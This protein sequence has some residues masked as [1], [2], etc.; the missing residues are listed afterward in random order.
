M[1]FSK[2][3]DKVP[4]KRLNYKLSWYGIRGDTL[5]WIS[6][7]LSARS[8]REVLDGASCDSAP[9]LSGVPQGTVRGP[10]LLL[11]YINDLPD[12]VVNSRPTVRLFADD[13]NFYRLIRNKKDSDLLQSDLDAV[14]SWENTL[15]TQFN[16]D[17]YF[18]MR[19]GKGKKYISKSIHYHPLQTTDSAK[20]LG[21]MLTSDL[22]Y[23]TH[24]SNTT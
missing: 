12:G 14:G 11:I 4:H 20:Y 9:V 19:T 3:F 22:K 24:I 2:A 15:L 6:N 1:D 17:K 16:A 8:Q 5:G 7:F 21:L 10:I 18:S 23:N 13:C